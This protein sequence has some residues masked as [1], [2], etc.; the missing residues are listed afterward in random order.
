MSGVAEKG[1][2]GLHDIKMLLRE[3]PLPLLAEVAVAT[4]AGRGI[5]LKPLGDTEFGPGY[6]RR[7]TAT[8]PDNRRFIDALREI[9]RRGS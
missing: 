7:T 2:G 9:F 5:L 4:L 3:N 6:M 1:G 8:P